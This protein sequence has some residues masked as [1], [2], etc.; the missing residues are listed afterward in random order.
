[1]N[2]CEISSSVRAGRRVLSV[3]GDVD[4]GSA[5]KLEAEIAGAV[6]DLD[7]GA[8]LLLDLS[9]VSFLDSSG[10]RALILGSDAVKMADVRL[11]FVLSPAVSRV[12]E[13][14]QLPPEAFG[15]AAP[16][17]SAAGW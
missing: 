1:M 15:I 14:T 6:E 10:L 8:D 17:W 5:E 7:P 13:V 11:A 3:V 4:L 2:G 12:L 9:G 16:D